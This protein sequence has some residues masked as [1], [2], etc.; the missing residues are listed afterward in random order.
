[1]VN[2]YFNWPIDS[3]WYGG[4]NDHSITHNSVL[5]YHLNIFGLSLYNYASKVYIA[6]KIV[7]SRLS[8]CS[9]CL[10]YLKFGHHAPAKQLNPGQDV[11]HH[12]CWDW[13][14][15]G[16][17]KSSLFS[18]GTLEKKRLSLGYSLLYVRI[19]LIFTRLSPF[20]SFSANRS[21]RQDGRVH[22]HPGNIVSQCCTHAHSPE[23]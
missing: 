13:T 22:Q 5:W 6:N 7:T 11:W 1:M 8:N 21:E 16:K 23:T 9:Q 2:S 15:A 10:V 3:Y 4:T 20:L 12:V 19:A 17:S 14:A 18:R